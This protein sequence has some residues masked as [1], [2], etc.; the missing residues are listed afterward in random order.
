MT[1]QPQQNNKFQFLRVNPFRGLLVDETTWADAHDYHRNQMR[2]H[3]LAMHG[4]GVVQGLD[5]VA[6]QPPDMK[7]TIRPGLGIDTEGR[8]LLLT[9]PQT[10]LIP[11]QAN[12][13][14]IFVVMEYDE[15]ATMMQNIT[16]GGTP[17]PARILEEC[18][19][20]ASLE[21]ATSGIELARISVEP[22][23]R[24]IRNPVDVLQAGNN[25]IDLSGRKLIGTPGAAQG[26]KAQRTVI[27]VGIIKHGA[28]N[29]VEWKR[30]SEGLRRLIR[31]TANGT[32]LDANVLE[33]VSP[34]D[35]AVVKNCKLLYMT[36]RSSFKF[37]P[38]EELA[39][40]R[41]MDRGGVLWCEPCRN[42]IPS[43][44]PDDFSRSCIELA[45][46]LN[47]Q[48]IQ[49][50]AG[51][52]LLSSRFLFA[53]PPA[54]VDPAGVVVEANRMIITTGD[55]GCLWEGR[56]Q[57]RVEAPSRE[58]LRSAQEFGANALFVAAG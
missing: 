38:E 29:S 54:A 19:I 15:K 37:S 41:F 52:P 51:H 25:E 34:L 56:G 57:E 44:T 18:T 24:Q 45:Q 17:Q 31:D 48:P 13:A 33:G 35:D 32:N 55:Y 42:G 8:M 47:R 16:E 23:S 49:P 3:L 43:G 39:L 36:G 28:P 10:I 50:R 2:F 14:T 11:G 58:A 1:S 30:H 12:F 5:V 6:S 22:N 26:G 4:V 9:E 21:A 20:R 40:R 53:V 27:S 46:R 7:V